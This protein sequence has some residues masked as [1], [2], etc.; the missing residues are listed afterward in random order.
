M[1]YLPEDVAKEIKNRKEYG[2]N[3]LSIINENKK[4]LHKIYSKIVIISSLFALPIII[5]SLFINY[6]FAIIVF[7]VYYAFLYYTI[8]WDKTC[9]TEEEDLL[10]ATLHP[11]IQK[12]QY[13]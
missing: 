3:L 11:D 10:N 8:T 6:I 7:F 5:V 2:S 13:R 12:K 9:P 4:H 1:L